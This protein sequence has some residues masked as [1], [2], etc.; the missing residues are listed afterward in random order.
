M[1]KTIL[2]PVSIPFASS[3]LKNLQLMVHQSEMMD[4][5]EKLLVLVAPTASGKTLANLLRI[6]NA[7]TDAIIVYPTK[8]L[9]KDQAFA[10]RNL[11]QEKL[12]RNARILD[13]DSLKSLQN[14]DADYTIIVATGDSLEE[15]GV[16]KGTVLR[17]LLH[18]PSNRRIL[19]TNVDLLYLIM[20]SY[21]RNSGDILR[22]LTDFNILVI[23]EFHMYS[24]I[25]FANLVF[26]IWPMQFFKQIILS[27][28]TPS[29]TLKQF[30]ELYD[31]PRLIQA[32]YSSSDNARTVRYRVELTL[33]PIERILGGEDVM[34]VADDI[35]QLYIKYKNS[36]AKVK[37]LVIVNS[38]AFCLHLSSYLK[39]RY[40]RENVAEIHGMV[41]DE[42]RDRKAI[43]VCTSAAEIGVDFDIASLVFEAWDSS[44]FMQRL[45][46][47]GRHRP[48]EGI[49]YV[50]PDLVDADVPPV[51][52]YSALNA[53]VNQKLDSLS[54]YA[55]FLKSDQAT[56]LFTG[57]IL[58]AARINMN[59]KFIEAVREV[60]T[61]LENRENA[62]KWLPP[63]IDI[64]KVKGNIR[65]PTNLRFLYESG[66]RGG[67]AGLTVLYD[68]V[69]DIPVLDQI[70]I[71]ELA[72]MDFTGNTISSN[73][74]YEKYGIKPK[75]WMNRQILI[76]RGFLDARRKISCK[77]K[78]HYFQ[79]PKPVRSNSR[80]N[81]DVNFTVDTGDCN[82]NEM[83][84]EVLDGTI[85]YF[86]TSKVDW[87]FQ[88]IRDPLD[89]GIF[90]LGAEALIQY[91]LDLP[92]RFK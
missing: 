44:A 61:L 2:Q 25:F 82:V 15:D 60:R 46:R 28:A 75:S 22:T 31:A 45:G 7:E 49:A 19:L 72:L 84:N 10:L 18:V 37:V 16:P 6:N 91:Y 68:G 34:R 14:H 59:Q 40:G 9:I 57:F 81:N 13:A 41:P 54:S 35:N 71:R 80:G 48:C 29:S 47:G 23:D 33:K 38:I 12:Q 67:I 92:I 32:P 70:S 85:G 30:S 90:V 11:I 8:E 3:G 83:I 50:P 36:N 51:C 69:F 73:K 89:H 55:D 20:K 74:V 24:G 88:T 5:Q 1:I 76:V 27:S 64:D 17:R 56:E 52:T 43:T 4:A 53:L 39:E 21:Y 77:C 58:G 65:I 66:A 63:F 87:R 86:T 78:P 26:T 62:R 79:S 42:L